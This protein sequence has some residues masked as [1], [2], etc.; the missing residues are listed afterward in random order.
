[1]KY[2]IAGLIGLFTALLIPNY[3]HAD[4]AAS[5]GAGGSIVLTDEA[6]PLHPSENFVLGA[7]N[8]SATIYQAEHYDKDSATPEIGC[9]YA[10]KP[11]D[12]DLADFNEQ[13]LAAT[14]DAPP[15]SPDE[16]MR[17][18]IPANIYIQSGVIFTMRLDSFQPVQ[19]KAKFKGDM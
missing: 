19:T 18:V 6:C 5:D 12:K 10:P 14:Q 9:W 8:A 11:T 4:V 17:I 3:S 13:M 1:M 15:R 16:Q 2:I 7:A